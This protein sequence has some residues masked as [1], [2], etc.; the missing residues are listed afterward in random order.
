MVTGKISIKRVDVEET[1]L[2]KLPMSNIHSSRE[3]SRMEENKEV[4]EI[5]VEVLEW[6]SSKLRS[7][8]HSPIK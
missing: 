4:V 1:T 6:P 2:I 8:N 7:P 3:V 5:I